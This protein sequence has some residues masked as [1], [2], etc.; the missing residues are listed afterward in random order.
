[1]SMIQTGVDANMGGTNIIEPLTTAVEKL[2]SKGREK[3]IFLL[4]DGEVGTGERNQII[5][6]AKQIP[7]TCKIHTFG[8]GRECDATLVRGTA[9]AGRGCAYFAHEVADLAKQVIEALRKSF[10]PSLANC[11]LRWS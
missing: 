8:V 6:F 7:T 3:R 4:T 2:D 1:M 5:N 9:E 11:S 10:E